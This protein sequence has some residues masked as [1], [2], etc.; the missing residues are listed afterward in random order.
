MVGIEIIF[1]TV[2][3]IQK[4]PSCKKVCPQEGYLEGGS[5]EMAVMVG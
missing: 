4:Q 1:D 3:L 2:N 5:Q